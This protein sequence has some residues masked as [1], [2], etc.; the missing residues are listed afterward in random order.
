[1]IAAPIEMIELDSRGVAY[2][3]GTRMKVKQVGSLYSVWSKV[4][5]TRRRSDIECRF[6]L[7]IG[8]PG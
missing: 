4:S 5:S 2:I 3:A 7:R 1:M 8:S 6:H